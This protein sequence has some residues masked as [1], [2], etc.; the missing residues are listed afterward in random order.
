M[1]GSIP[2]EL[3]KLTNLTVL[4]LGGNPLSGRISSE[5]GKLTNLTVL[6]LG[7]SQLSG[8][9]P[10]ELGNLTYLMVLYLDG[11]QLRGCV[12]AVWRDVAYN[13]LFRLGLPCCDTPTSAPEERAALVALYGATNGANWTNRANWLSDKPLGEWHGVTIDFAG[14]VTGLDLELNRL[15][16]EIPSELGNLTNLMWMFLLGNPLS[17][18]IPSEL[19]KLS[20]LTS[21]H[22]HTNRLSGSIPSELGKLTNLQQLF[23]YSNQLRGCVPAAWR[24][25]AYNDLARLGLPFCDT[26]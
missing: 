11:N 19:G 3:G 26:P 6:D 16:G 4:D 23:L 21:L 2:S 20:N 7:F 15:S 8:E 14:R 10:S 18:S 9:I 5:L 17:G 24:D 13:D 22:L 12:P 25:V 1:S